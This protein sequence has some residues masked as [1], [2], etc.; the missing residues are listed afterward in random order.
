[1]VA[2]EIHHGSVGAD[3]CDDDAVLAA[4]RRAVDDLVG[5]VVT[6]ELRT[7]PLL[8]VRTAGPWRVH[9]REGHELGRQPD[10][11]VKAKLDLAHDAIQVRPVGAG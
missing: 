6:V 3:R 8:T 11:L 7:D 10:Q 9:R 5:D 1:M 4:C 2:M